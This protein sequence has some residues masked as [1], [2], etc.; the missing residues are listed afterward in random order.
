[1]HFLNNG[2]HALVFPPRCGTRWIAGVLYDNGLIDTKGPHHKFEWVEKPNIDTFMFVRNPFTRERSIHRWLAEVNKIDINS[3]T[4]EDYIDSEEFYTEGSW[5][6]RYGNLNNYVTHI[7]LE[8]LN[9]FLE[10]TLEIEAPK[11]NNLYHMEDD[12][13]N[14]DD[15]FKN[16]YIIDKI[17]EK[18]KEDL[19]HIK[20]DLTSYI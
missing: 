1:M 13:R 7:H 5:Y 17:L 4:F 9:E 16:Q 2:K 15:I 12:N 18:Y 20:F 11:Y 8:K 3:F 6:T 19:L 10:N 14:D